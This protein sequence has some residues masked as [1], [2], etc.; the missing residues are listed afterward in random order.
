MDYYWCENCGGPLVGPDVR[1]CPHCGTVFGGVKGGTEQQRLSAHRRFT[2]FKFRKRFL[3]FR[4][5]VKWTK[6][7]AIPPLGLVLLYFLSRQFFTVLH[8][9]AVRA[10]AG[11]IT[12]AVGMGAALTLILVLRLHHRYKLIAYQLF[13]E[14]AAERDRRPMYLLLMG[15]I[16]TVVGICCL[17]I[18]LYES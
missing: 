2:K 10:R 18:S 4:P 1:S 13:E 6:L 5:L 9:S 8:R 15:I 16:W 17:I 3:W 12:A 14:A 7:L 11:L